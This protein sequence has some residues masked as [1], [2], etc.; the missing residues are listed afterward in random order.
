MLEL[1]LLPG[2]SDRRLCGGPGGD[3]PALDRIDR[4]RRRPGRTPGRRCR[5]QDAR[6]KLRW[7]RV[8]HQGGGN[9][10]EG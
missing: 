7:L 2:L 5:S 6:P 4:G 3:G 8:L 1:R 9:G 10:S